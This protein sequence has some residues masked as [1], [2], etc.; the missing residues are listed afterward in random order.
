M[1][2]RGEVPQTDSQTLWRQRTAH[3]YSWVIRDPALEGPLLA[4]Q[5]ALAVLICIVLFWP[6][7]IGL[8]LTAALWFWSWHWTPSIAGWSLSV[9]PRGL[10]VRKV[11]FRKRDLDGRS[12]DLPSSVG[13]W[14]FAV[15]KPP[16]TRH[17]N[18]DEIAEIR[19]QGTALFLVLEDSSVHCIGSTRSVDL[20]GTSEAVRLQ[21]ALIG[22]QRGFVRSPE[23]DRAQR[24]AVQ[25]LSE[26]PP[27]AS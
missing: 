13:P 4:Q 19:G 12:L 14:L 23:E 25:T 24:V 1:S 2:D 17:F 3:G 6:L 27:N 15:G 9:G 26:S 5:V 21:Q 22:Y 20:D 8:F 18:W 16:E 11:Y 7:G 10:D